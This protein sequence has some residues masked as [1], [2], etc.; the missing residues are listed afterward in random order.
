M[1][2]IKK[3]IKMQWKVILITILSFLFLENV[4]ALIQTVLVVVALELLALQIYEYII[5]FSLNNE[6]LRALFT[7][8]DNK[9][10]IIETLGVS[11]FQAS[12]LLSA[13]LLVAIVS[14]GIYFIQFAP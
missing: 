1:K 7:G 3:F 9:F 5:K 6:Y 13:H 10:S 8:E 4:K 14:Y 11:K 12:A 2:E